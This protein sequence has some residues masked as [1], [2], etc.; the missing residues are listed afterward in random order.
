MVKLD[1]ADIT[2]NQGSMPLP[3]SP[4]YKNALEEIE[5]VDESLLDATPTS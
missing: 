5:E 2:D 3:Y 4:M 1:E